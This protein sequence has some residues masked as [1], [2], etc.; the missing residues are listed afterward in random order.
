MY[1]TNDAV[2]N[3]ACPAAGTVQPS[4][5]DL[6][7][8]SDLSH[9]FGGLE[10]QEQTE[11]KTDQ[12]NRFSSPDP[13]IITMVITT[14]TSSSST[15]PQQQQLN[16]TATPFLPAIAS[17]PSLSDAAL[18][19]TL[20]LL[21]EP[22]SEL[23]ALALP[24]M[25][26][27]SFASYDDLAATLRDQ[28]LDLAD[29]VRADE[30]GRARLYAVLGSHPR[31]GECRRGGGKGKG[32]GEEELSAQSREEQRHL[33]KPRREQ[34]GQVEEEE[35]E[36][37]DELARLN[38]EYEA[39]FPGLRYV[40]WVNGRGRGEILADMRRRIERGDPREEEREV[41]RVSFS[42]SLPSLLF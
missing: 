27:L 29:A 4:E 11:S 25:R 33:A 38:A 14:T 40:T 32:E 34:G 41:I 6:S 3:H 19:A 26:A 7:L 24:T 20:D 10:S 1:S 31:L 37:E 28:L 30:A 2:G 42:A 8:R 17:L 13:T 18:R 9:S 21:F 36:G 23:H 39:R 35:E 5:R 12:F 22:S 16:P 15:A